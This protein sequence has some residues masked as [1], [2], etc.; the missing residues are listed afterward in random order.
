MLEP[1]FPVNTP[2]R[3]EMYF[4]LYPDV[5]GP[6]PMITMEILQEGKVVAA[7]SMPFKTQL[8]NN[9]QEGKGTSVVGELQHGFDYL[10]AMNVE[11]MSASRC[12]ARLTIRQGGS[13]VTRLANFQIGS[14]ETATAE[15]PAEKKTSN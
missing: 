8:R 15:K 3:V 12:Q 11:K 4:I 2:F 5:Y 6:Q 10:A 14:G 1:V 7:A 9:T 13:V